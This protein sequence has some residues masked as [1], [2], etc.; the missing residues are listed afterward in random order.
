M[1]LFG[2]DKLKALVSKPTPGPIES[3]YLS[4]TVTTQEL[5]ETRYALRYDQQQMVSRAVSEVYISLAFNAN[6]LS[7]VPIRLMKK[8]TKAARGEKVRGLSKAQKAWLRDRR[9]GTK[10]SQYAEAAGEAVEVT[11]S[12]AIALLNNP[13]APETGAE[14]MR[15]HWLTAQSTGDGYWL[16]NATRK[17][18]PT[19]LDRLLSQ[20]TSIKLN[21]QGVK[22]YNYGRERTK[23][24]TFPFESVIHFKWMPGLN[25]PW[26]GEG[27]IK[28]IA[29]ECDSLQSAIQTSLNRWNNEGLPPVL[30]EYK[31]SS[32]Q[33]S[34]G[35][36][37]GDVPPSVGSEECGR[38][39]HRWNGHDGNAA[40]VAQQ[41]HSVPRREERPA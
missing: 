37:Q 34:R 9:V 25:N 30:G 35:T 41:R 4:G 33:G 27:W 19:T 3:Q 15:G 24:Q 28:A 8:G 2:L 20:F 38:S 5:A 10:A 39:V 6:Q 32:R 21:E 17:L 36:D 12:D 7:A 1:T 11:D 26:Y 40:P 31:G 16:H 22:E 18:P 29:P 13:N 14:F 23:I